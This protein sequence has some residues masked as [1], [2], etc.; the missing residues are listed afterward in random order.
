[1][2]TRRAR[3][4]PPCLT[5]DILETWSNAEPSPVQQTVPPAA[6]SW[7]SLSRGERLLG[8]AIVFLIGSWNVVMIDLARAPGVS[9]SWVVVAVWA[10][11]L[12]IHV[13]IVVATVGRE[14]ADRPKHGL[15]LRRRVVPR[16]I[17]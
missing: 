17:P 9:W 7:E 3:V 8:H 12:L 5:A 13:S 2:R 11:A 10:A 14:N 6:T 15:S 16:H 4:S 1:M